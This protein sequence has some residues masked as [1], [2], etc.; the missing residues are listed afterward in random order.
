MPSSKP[1]P[2]EAASYYLN[3]I[4]RADGVSIHHALGHASALLHK[5][6][7][8]VR[9]DK[10][11]YR[12]AEGKWTIKDI[13]QHLI[14]SERVFA[15]RAMRFARQDGTEL[16]GFDENEYV[17]SSSTERRSVADLLEEH[18]IVR[19]STEKLFESFS[20]DMLLRQ[21]TANGQ[22]VSVRALGWIIAGH[23]VHHAGVIRERYL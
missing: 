1:G 7:E 18:D 5:T 8:G 15:Y 6:V 17:A 16:P 13:L 14:D 22:N 20:P 9:A 21:G 2:D 12:Y 11:E 23:A 19:S 4:Q 10:A 3:Y